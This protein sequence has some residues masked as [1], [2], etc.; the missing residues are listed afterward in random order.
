MNV[1]IQLLKIYTAS[2]F[3]VK[4]ITAF[5]QKRKK[6]GDEDETHSSPVK[7]I[8]IAVLFIVLGVEILIFF[9]VYALALYR[10]TKA[11]HNMRL[12]FEIAVLLA[13]TIS[14]FFGFFTAASTYYIGE[15]EEHL[16]SLPIKAHTL[17]AAKF[18]A[19]YINAFVTSVCCLAPVI[20]VYGIY[21]NPNIVFYIWAVLCTFFIP[22]PVV[23]LCFAFTILLMRFTRFF[24]NKNVITTIG[25]SIGIILS[26]VLNY[27]VQSATETKA[28]TAL[29]KNLAAQSALLEPYGAYYPPVKLVGG[30]LINPLSFHAV[31]YACILVILTALPPAFVIFCMSK[32]YTDSL[33]G[34]GEKKIARLGAK[35]GDAYIKKNIRESA[36]MVSLVKREFIMMN[37]T[38]MY[39]LN[40]PFTIVILPVLFVVIFIARGKSFSSIPSSVYAFMNGS[41]GFAIVGIIAGFLGA[42]TNIADTTLSRDAKYIPLIKSLPIDFKTFM[43]AKLIHAMLFAVF[44][45]VVGV[46]FLAFVFKLSLLQ[47]IFASLTGFAFSF[48]LNEIAL[49][50]DT[51]HPKLN[52]DNP[53]AA[54]KENANIFFVFLFNS[55]AAGLTVFAF[56]FLRGAQTWVVALCFIAFPLLVALLLLK[57]YG[58]YAEKSLHSLEV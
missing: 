57:L 35:E 8:G 52:W 44:A 41:S 39:L 36:V 3:N 15:I 55:I 21:E 30:I 54:M 51:A 58:G 18:T 42:M 32:L 17:C 26:L 11:M 16:L 14:L 48:I 2:V 1:F 34:F 53:V 49:F 4:K 46:G 28:F 56:Y 40:G 23:S 33:V 29:A 24:R 27:V 22:L 5:I 9:G 7:L 13:S 43:Y 10:A 38:P 45:I 6:K 50:L 20:L 12:L 19:T 47:I 31:L 25:A 37:R